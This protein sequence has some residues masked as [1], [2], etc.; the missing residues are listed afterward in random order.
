MTAKVCATDFT[1]LETE[2]QTLQD[3]LAVEQ[4]KVS[5]LRAELEATREG[6][7]QVLTNTK[8]KAF[9]SKVAADLL[10]LK[11]AFAAYKKEYREYIR[12]KAPG[13]IL[14]DQMLLER[15][16]PQ[17]K[18]RSV[19]DTW[20]TFEHEGGLARIYVGEVTQELRDLFACD[21]PVMP[22]PVVAPAVVADVE[23][24]LTAVVERGDSTVA[25]TRATSSGRPYDS[26]S[27]DL[28]PG[29]SYK[30]VNGESTIA[31][32]SDV[33][34]PPPGKTP[35]GNDIIYENGRAI[36]LLTKHLRPNSESSK[37]LLYHK[38]RTGISVK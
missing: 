21:E 8:I 28:N 1:A 26:A 23:A 11:E 17:L 20:F 31:I 9:D 27:A 18:V 25:S 6:S 29:Q 19:N 32:R 3:K 24:P 38:P 2:V 14:K 35:D 34:I 12:Q 13:M 22:A 37:K 30:T 5:K 15:N 16:F 4:K 10:E 7:E 36:I 33:A